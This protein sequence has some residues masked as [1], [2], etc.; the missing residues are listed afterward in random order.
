MEHKLN[1]NDLKILYFGKEF[2]KF[3]YASHISNIREIWLYKLIGLWI[4]ESL[5]FCTQAVLIILSS[6]YIIYIGLERDLLGYI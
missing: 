4:Y 5:K 2:H 6:T 3:S 1:D